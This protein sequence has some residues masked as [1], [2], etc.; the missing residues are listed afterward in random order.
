MCPCAC[1]RHACMR[2]HS[3][4]PVPAHTRAGDSVCLPAAGLGA[5]VIGILG[6]CFGGGAALRL[7]SSGRFAACGGIHASGMESPGGE[8]FIAQAKCPIMLLQ[9]GGDTP[10]TP[11]FEMVKTLGPEIAGA[12]VLR[13]Y[14]DQNHGWCGAMGD[15]KGDARLKAAVECALRTTVA[16]FSRA[17]PSP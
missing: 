5:K 14:W 8:A 2:T 11:V 6:F 7:A 9:A 17:L 15:R 4:V 1:L 13:T 3:R 16:F 12:S 10:L